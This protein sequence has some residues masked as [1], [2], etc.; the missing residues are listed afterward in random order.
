[1]KLTSGLPVP[2]DDLSK[3]SAENDPTQW[4]SDPARVH[5]ARGRR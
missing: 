3:L 5:L 2:T 1:M 4:I